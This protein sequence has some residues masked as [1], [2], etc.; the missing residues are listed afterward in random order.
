MNLL[1]R[2]IAAWTAC[3]AVLLAALAPSISHAIS[4]A[5]GTNSIWSDICTQAGMTRHTGMHGDK[6]AHMHG[7]M[8]AD[9]QADMQADRH[10]SKHADHSGP[11]QKSLHFEH[12]PFCFTHGG[13]VGLPPVAAISLPIVTATQERPFLF[14]Q[15]PRPLFIWAAAQSRAPPFIA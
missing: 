5:K 11:V 9:M 8:H 15:S 12:C 6:H 1:T 4:A 10:T 2:R 3:F 13:S 14:Y 7:N